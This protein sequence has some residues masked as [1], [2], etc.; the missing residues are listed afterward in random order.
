[1]LLLLFF[2]GCVYLFDFVLFIFIYYFNFIIVVV[3]VSKRKRLLHA[4]Q[5]KCLVIRP[6]VWV[7][8]DNVNTIFHF[9]LTGHR[10]K[11]EY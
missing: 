9:R 3:V 5:T 6:S 8:S 4:Y 2:W 10:N 1:M 11:G 7:S